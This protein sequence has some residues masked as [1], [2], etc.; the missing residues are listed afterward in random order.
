MSLSNEIKIIVKKAISDLYTTDIDET[1]ITINLTKPEFEGDY[2]LVLF[3][4]LKPLKKSPDVLGNELGKFLV[5]KHA[6]IFTSYNI[7]KGFLNLVIADNYWI[8]FLSD[9][10]QQQKFR[11]TKYQP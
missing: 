4:L 3:A 1:G 10:L 7:I 9:N 2:T 11:E 8:K 6:E 5:E